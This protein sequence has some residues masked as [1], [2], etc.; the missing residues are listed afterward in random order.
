[1][2]PQFPKVGGRN[3][4]DLG[5]RGE[6][7]FEDAGVSAGRHGQPRLVV[8]EGE[9]PVGELQ[10][11]LARLKHPAVLVFQER[12]ENPVLQARIDRAPVDVEEGG[13]GR[14]GAVFQDVHPPD[15]ARVAD[16]H[17]VGH[18]VEDQAHAALAEGGGEGVKVVR[19]AQLKIE[20]A[21]VADVVAVTAAGAGLQ[22]GGG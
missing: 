11:D 17:V 15:V 14:S 5:Q 10:A 21:V 2:A 19:A 16:A 12:Q 4:R 3:V 8:A 9:G 6:R 13:E 18:R 20:T 22:D 1:D 7:S